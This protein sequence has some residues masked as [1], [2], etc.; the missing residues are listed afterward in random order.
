MQ[1]AWLRLDILAPK[2]GSVVFGLLG[3]SIRG[4]CSPN[5]TSH[6]RH[7]TDP[8]TVLQPDTTV[9]YQSPS[10]ERI[11]GYSP[12]DLLGQRFDRFAVA[13]DRERLTHSVAACAAGEDARRW[14]AR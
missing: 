9:S 11:L 1:G 3:R 14:N 2:S 12:D 5:A 6:V 13:D 4:F 8:I 10:I 7:A